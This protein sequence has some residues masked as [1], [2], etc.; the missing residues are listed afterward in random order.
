MWDGT[1]LL[2]VHA[3][4]VQPL[5][6]AAW[7]QPATASVPLAP[8]SRAWVHGTPS[9]RWGSAL[10]TASAPA[11][12]SPQGCEV[13]P[14]VFAESITRCAGTAQHYPATHVLLRRQPRG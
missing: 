4:A 7:N 11:A 9:V 14:R 12:V 1:A 2:K 3:R 13:H 6:L 5:A 8:M 10:P